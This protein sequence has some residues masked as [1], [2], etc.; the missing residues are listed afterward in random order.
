MLS[1]PRSK[2]VGRD[3]LIKDDDSSSGGGGRAGGDGG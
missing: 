1:Q 2:L 3:Q